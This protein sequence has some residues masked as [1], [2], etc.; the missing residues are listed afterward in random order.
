MIAWDKREVSKRI[1][2]DQTLLDWIMEGRYGKTKR[3]AKT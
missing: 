2:V 1:I 3:E